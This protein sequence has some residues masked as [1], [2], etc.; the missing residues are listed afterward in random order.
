MPQLKDIYTE[1]L[2]RTGGTGNVYQNVLT[3]GQTTNTYR[4]PRTSINP[5]QPFIYIGPGTDVNTPG[6]FTGDDGAFLSTS[7]IKN[8]TRLAPLGLG[9]VSY[10]RDNNRILKFLASAAGARFRTTQTALQLFNP[11]SRTKI[12]NEAGIIA[13]LVPGVHAGRFI[14]TE[15]GRILFGRGRGSLLDRIKNIGD[16]YRTKL[17]GEPTIVSPITLG[18]VGGLNGYFGTK[19]KKS[20]QL[21]ENF[22]AEEFSSLTNPGR[23]RRKSNI[24]DPMNSQSPTSVGSSDTFKINYEFLQNKIASSTDTGPAGTKKTDTD[25]I[26]FRF[27]PFSG[28]K[29]EELTYVP[30]RAFISRLTENVKPEFNEQRYV[31][32]TERFITYAGAKRTTQL[33]FNIATFSEDEIKHTWARVNYLTGLAFPKGISQ[34]G[35]IQPQLFRI[36]IGGIYE[37]QP[38]YIETL[39]YDF[40]DEFTTFDITE[41]VSQVINVKMQ[42]SLI[43]KTTRY[44]NSPF[45]KIME[46]L[47]IK[48]NEALP[49]ITRKQRETADE[50]ARRAATEAARLNNLLGRNIYSILNLP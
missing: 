31:G 50:V 3:A 4:T 17:S 39:D 48:Q 36:T 19:P 21:L 9:S 45:Y 44:Y 27:S 10:A 11:Y 22:I 46:N 14:D 8:D 43:E 42:L 32:R 38:C 6:V 49:A 23:A 7:N 47:A 35:F 34:S 20:K 2:G 13:S 25:I 12:F 40:L 26:T 37:D 33:E 41:G 1:N 30:F 5:N 16:H 28:D 24:T 18:P 15:P 29:S